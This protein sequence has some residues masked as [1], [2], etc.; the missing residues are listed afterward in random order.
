MAFVGGNSIYSGCDAGI[1]KIPVN[2][3]ATADRVNDFEHN[4]VLSFIFEKTGID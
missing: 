3:Q 4:T 1:N 2:I